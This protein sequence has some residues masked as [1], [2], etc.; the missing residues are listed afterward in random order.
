[1]QRYGVS[2]GQGYAEMALL[3]GDPSDGLPGV[4]GIGEKTAAA[5]LARYGD[6]AG[7]RAAVASA[8]SGL[9][10]TQRARLEAAADYLDAAPVVVRVARDA[11]LPEVTGELPTRAADP[12]ALLAL[13]E[14]WGLESSVARVVSALGMQ[15]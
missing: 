1:A 4:P 12:E 5:L 9:T 8:D 3:R 15:V 11:P 2:T 13:I 10:A 14:R 7:L 6:L